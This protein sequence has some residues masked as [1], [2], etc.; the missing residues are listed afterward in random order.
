MSHAGYVVR[1][2]GLRK[3]YRRSPWGREAV[4][5]DRLD[6][7]VESGEVFGLLGPNGSG[8]S[9]FFKILAGLIRPSA[10]QGW[11]FDRMVGDPGIN[12]QVGYLPDRVA[13]YDYLTGEESLRLSGRLGG[14]QGDTLNRRVDELLEL[15]GLQQARLVRL[16]EYSKG[17]LQ[18]IAIAQ[19]VVHNPD[20]LILDEPMSGLD[21]L[22][23]MNVRKLVTELKRQNKTILF[24]THLLE[25][26]ETLCERV[27]ILLNGRLETVGTIQETL[28]RMPQW[29]ESVEAYRLWARPGRSISPVG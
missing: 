10:G 24:S 19:A 21:L 18:R 20:L 25:D 27:G 4:A 15:A 16:R 3:T 1:T 2:V 23:R 6:L 14:L 17:M 11:L 7:A 26:V 29:A 22:G 13:C 5:L 8:K 12:A 28:R 9:T